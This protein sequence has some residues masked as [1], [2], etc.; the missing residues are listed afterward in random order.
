MGKI[1]MPDASDRDRKTLLEENADKIEKTD[2]LKPLSPEDLDIRRETLT[3]NAIALSEMED[4]KKDTMADFK[5][6]MDPLTKHNKLLLSEIKTR[7]AK[8]EGTLYHMAN[9]EEGMMETYDETGEMILSRRLRPEEKQKTIFAA[10]KT[11]S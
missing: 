4:E 9:H 3:D 11:G 5:A 2:Y 6:K 1:F 8:C 7:Q 10:L